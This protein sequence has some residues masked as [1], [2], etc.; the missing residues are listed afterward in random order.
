MHLKIGLDPRA[1]LFLFVVWFSSVFFCKSV[2]SLML[3]LASSTLILSLISSPASVLS[4]L[5]NFVPIVLLAFPLWTFLNK[6]SLFHASKGFDLSLGLFMT[7]RLLSIV[8][9][10]IAFLISVRPTEIVRALN[11]L[12][13]PPVVTAVLALALRTLYIIA[14]DY[15]SIKEAH[16]SRG[17]E[18]D[19][20]SLIRRIRSHIPLLLPLMIRSI[21][22]AEKMVLA[23]ELR[24]TLLTSRRSS[25]LRARDLLI[26]LGCLSL[27]ALLL[28]CDRILVS[29]V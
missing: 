10:S 21:D 11:S 15:R 5:R 6:W 17:L 29:S 12:R 8:I 23:L 13:V 4:R 2:Y 26:S 25:P 22:N 28:Y 20:G 1:K 3:I 24:P 16:A 18:L 14:E 19:R 9:I 27:I 7:I